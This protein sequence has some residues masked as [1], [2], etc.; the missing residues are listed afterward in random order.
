MTRTKINPLRLGGIA[1]AVL[2][3]MLLPWLAPNQFYIHLGTIGCLNLMFV[4]GLAI[5]SR[6]GQLSMG[7]A[8]FALVGDCQGRAEASPNMVQ[9]QVRDREVGRIRIGQSGPSRPGVGAEQDVE[10]IDVGRAG[11]SAQVSTQPQQ[12]RQGFPQGNACS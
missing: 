1:I 12:R 7:H 11:N 2:A 9:K 5:I 4:L 8:G 6:A 10:I 3:A